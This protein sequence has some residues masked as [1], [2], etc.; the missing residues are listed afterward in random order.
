MPTEVA[1]AATSQTVVRG[2]KV[3]LASAYLMVAA[4]AA[5]SRIVRSW[6]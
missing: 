1:G 5:M 3:Q 4:G 6:A 2:A